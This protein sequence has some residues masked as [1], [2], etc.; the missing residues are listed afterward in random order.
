MRYTECPVT[1]A[2]V[3]VLKYQIQQHPQKNL[4]SSGGLKLLVLLV[5]LKRI[6]WRTMHQRRK[7]RDQLPKPSL[8]HRILGLQQCNSLRPSQFNLLVLHILFLFTVYILCPSLSGGESSLCTSYGYL[9]SHP[10]FQHLV[11]LI[12]RVSHSLPRCLDLR[13]F[14]CVCTLRPASIVSA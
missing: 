7:A 12:A 6:W 11:V 5:A 4:P 10:G 14:K 3:L 8:E 1:A 2:D 9:R 13:P